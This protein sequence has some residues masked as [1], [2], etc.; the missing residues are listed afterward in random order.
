MILQSLEFLENRH[1]VTV[2]MFKGK[3]EEVDL[4]RYKMRFPLFKFHLLDLPMFRHWIVGWIMTGRPLPLQVAMYTSRGGK[5]LIRSILRDQHCNVV[6]ADML[7]TSMLFSP[8]HCISVLELD[9]L[10]SVR[11]LH[12][13]RAHSLNCP[14]GTYES[15]MSPFVTKLVNRFSTIVLKY[16]RWAIDR[17]ERDSAR[18]HNAV[19]LVSQAEAGLL[20]QMTGAENVYAVPP[21]T[22]F[23]MTVERSAP[24]GGPINLM[25]FGNMQTTANRESIRYVLTQIL[26][27]LACQGVDY[28]LYAVGRCP[29]EIVESHQDTRV[30]FTGFIE[31]A[32][33]LFDRI[34][35]HLAPMFGGTGIKTKILECLARGIPTITTSD[36]VIGLS[37]KS[38][39][40]LFICSDA[41]EMAL[42]C[43]ELATDESLYRR[44]SKSSV[45]F[46]AEQ[47]NFDTNQSRY[48]NILDACMTG[49]ST[50][51]I[52]AA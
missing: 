5:R 42:R 51:A 9:D 28:R 4:D 36:G 45:R 12:N 6:I 20:K 15:R 44:L 37:A 40:Q 35:I 1:D 2:V 22:K 18:R 52:V 30:I 16:E 27:M 31:N 14:L 43:V 17:M 49:P 13:I 21:T 33:D 34:H 38:G 47:F 46:A 24:R 11:Y 7:R 50:N 23:R 29:R 3:E 48:L 26:P 41:K 10:L 39:E 8:E 25:F 32:E 19:V